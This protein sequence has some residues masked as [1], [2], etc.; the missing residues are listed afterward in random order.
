M[1]IKLPPLPNS[2]IAYD[3]F[4]T[5]LVAYSADQ[6]QVYATQA[7]T[8]ALA[9]LQGEAVCHLKVKTSQWSG[10]HKVVVAL[11][12]DPES[13]PV[14]THP[15]PAPAQQP[16]TDQMVEASKVCD[17][18]NERGIFIDGWISAETAHGIEGKK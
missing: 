3:T 17:A 10:L 18:Y 2:I 9:E 14:Y 16:L 11:P 4:H 1:S 13:V 15:A 6:M 8:E 5:Q 7:V 12:S